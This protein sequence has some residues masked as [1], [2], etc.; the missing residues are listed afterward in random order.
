MEGI[1]KFEIFGYTFELPEKYEPIKMIGKG[2]YGAV[3]SATNKENNKGVAIKKLSKIEDIIDAKR[4]LREII[5][6][7]NLTHENILGLLDVVYIPND[8]ETLGDVY[9][10]TELME[11][12]LNRV[13]R[14]KQELSDEHI[15]YFTYQILRAFKFIHSANIIH[16]DLKP[17]NILLNE[18]CDL[19]LCDFGLSRSLSIQKQE[20]LT[21]YVVT[22]FYR[23]PE[24]MLSSHSYSNSVDVWSIGCTLCEI[25][26]GKIIFPGEN[27]IEQV[28]LILEKRGTPDAETM[29][30][31]SNENAKKYIESL[32]VKPK[33]PMKE[34]IPYHDE[35]ALDLIDQLL[36]FN[37]N[38]RI[39]I[40]E[41]IKH[42]YLESLHDPEDEPVFEG[43]IDFDFEN[44]P[45]LTL[46]DV[47]KLILQEISIYNKAY[48][49]LL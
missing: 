30:M 1:Q 46:E 42:P 2:T 20:D 29:E 18:H 49:D 10:V 39:S 14:S 5:I 9:L 48:Y 44:D 19:K 33:T 31:I 17:S 47:K 15:A 36:E 43:S 12:D 22:R 25:I 24:I 26:S 34:L 41:A 27:Y 45:N 35:K 6:M 23:A 3:V 4:V 28:N 38:R 32:E 11:T 7:K 21:E 40:D 37:S 8:T 13:I 16:R